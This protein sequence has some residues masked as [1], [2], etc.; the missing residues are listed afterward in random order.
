MRL[1]L[2]LAIFLLLASIP[3]MA[4]QSAAPVFSHVTIT[5]TMDGARCFCALEP[6]SEVTCCPNYS[7]SVD[8][9]GTVIYDGRYGAKV[10][11][12]KV[13]SVS[14]SAVR[15][16]VAEFYRIDFFSR[17]DRYVIKKPPYGNSV[18]VVSVDHGYASTISIDIDGK[19]KSIYIFY[20]A[21]QELTD[22]QGKLF[23]AL[24]VAQY[25]GRA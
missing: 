23:D 25:L 5:L 24:Q 2:L 3:A 14:A 22:L 21:P 6:G 1:L 4:Q 16:L 18:T 17:E 7:V 11:G 20:G 8:E 9:K 10:R 13:H 12:Q 19:K 15:D